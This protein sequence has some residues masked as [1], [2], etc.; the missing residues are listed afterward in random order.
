M[1]GP[2]SRTLY[3]KPEGSTITPSLLLLASRKAI[4]ASLPLGSDM[5]CGAEAARGGWMAVRY[6][7]VSHLVISGG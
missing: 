4:P 1:P 6:V 5:W 7:H 3:C 2:S